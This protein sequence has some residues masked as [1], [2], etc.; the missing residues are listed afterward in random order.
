MR[1]ANSVLVITSYSIHYTK[2]YDIANEASEQ[3][4]EVETT[5][6]LSDNEVILDIRSPDEHEDKPFEPDGKTVVHLPFYKLSTKFG[7]LDQ[8]KTYLLYCERGVMSKLQALYLKEQGFQNVK[9]YRH[10]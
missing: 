10:A 5:S 9:V 2:L 7:D 6:E 4:Q 8:S 3:V 1:M